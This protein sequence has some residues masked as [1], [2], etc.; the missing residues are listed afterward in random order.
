MT[1]C[2]IR[3]EPEGITKLWTE[4]EATKCW[5]RWL[6][7]VWTQLPKL[8]YNVQVPQTRV[9]LTLRACQSFDHLQETFPETFSGTG[10]FPEAIGV[11]LKEA[12]S[13]LSVSF[14]VLE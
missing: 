5:P 1:H 14:M 6:C 8:E 12:Q 11:I 3:T 9:E 4:C 7:W 2:I 10:N 13:I